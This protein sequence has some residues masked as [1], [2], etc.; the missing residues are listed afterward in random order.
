MLSSIAVPVITGLA[1]NFLSNLFGGNKSKPEPQPQ[2]NY[3][4]VMPMP[5]FD[6]VPMLNQN[7]ALTQAQSMVNPLYDQQLENT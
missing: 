1:T 2:A 4:P 7:Q 3:Q 5:E 6:P